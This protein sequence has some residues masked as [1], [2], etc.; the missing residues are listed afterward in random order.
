MSWWNDKA[1]RLQ[2][3]VRSDEINR[4]DQYRYSGADVRRSIVHGREDIVL[5][6][7]HLD[8]ANFQLSQIK[9]LLVVIAA[10]LGYLALR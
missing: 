3:G 7:S 10:L 6:V 8:A 9:W 5:L 1:S 4:S 2:S